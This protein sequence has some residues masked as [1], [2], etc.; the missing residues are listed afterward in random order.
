VLAIHDG[1][2]IFFDLARAYRWQLHDNFQGQPSVAKGIIYAINAGALNARAGVDRQPAL[3][4]GGAGG[5]R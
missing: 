5:R 1:R 3:G 2:L 4:M